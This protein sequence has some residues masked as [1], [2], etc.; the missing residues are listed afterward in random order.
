MK[1]KQILLFTLCI[2][3]FACNTESTESPEEKEDTTLLK[4]TIETDSDGEAETTIYTYDDNKL[5]SIDSGDGWKN[6]YTYENEKLVRDDQYTDNELTAYLTLEYN[7]TGK[8]TN[9][10]EY[11]LEPSGLN[12]AHKYILTYNSDNTIKIENYFGDFDSQ[13]NLS[14]T[15]TFSYN[16][17]N[18][19]KIED[20]DNSSPEYYNV[21]YDN[22]NGMFK[23]VNAIDVLNIVTELSEFSASLYGNTN[24]PTSIA[25]IYHQETLDAFE[26][27]YNDNNYPIKATYHDSYQGNIDYTATIEYFYE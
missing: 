7:S 12:G 19:F 11:F 6:I 24:N 9:I 26:Y 16:G 27:T 20:D 3:F 17:K 2:T 1:L 14:S 10:K 5:T 25:G 15:Y 13:T 4:K 8:L 22:K 23:N 21:I 18:I